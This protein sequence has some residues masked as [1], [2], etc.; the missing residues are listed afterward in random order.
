MNVSKSENKSHPFAARSVER[1]SED[2][3]PAGRK[4]HKTTR[5]RA[6]SRRRAE[7]SQ[8]AISPSRTS[9]AVTQTW[10]NLILPVESYDHEHSVTWPLSHQPPRL[11]GSR[12]D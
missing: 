11:Q 7:T 3:A 1:G 6:R 8:E 4:P 12:L 2:G 5:A 9:T 10:A